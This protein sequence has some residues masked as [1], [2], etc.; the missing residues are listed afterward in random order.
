MTQ[1]TN[2][3]CD[4]KRRKLVKYQQITDNVRPCKF[5]DVIST[6]AV[7]NGTS[8]TARWRARR[9][10]RNPMAR[11]STAK[12]TVPI[13]IAMIVAG[14]LRLLKLSIGCDG[15]NVAIENG[16]SCKPS[17]ELSIISPD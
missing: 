3:L 11:H 16:A 17:I 4:Q 14:E 13:T 1:A 8:E 10:A 7:P 12:A 6:V 9:R 5:T 15:A 2:E